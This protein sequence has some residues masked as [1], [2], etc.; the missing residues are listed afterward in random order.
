MTYIYDEF[1]DKLKT[2]QNFSLVRYGDGEW[3]VILKKEPLYSSVILRRF[4]KVDG[5]IRSGDVMLNIIKSSPKYYFGLQ[6]LALNL[7]PEDI[8]NT[9]PADVNVVNSD[10]LHRLSEMGSLGD[11]FE[12]L[13]TR[14]L[15]LLGPEY[16]KNLKFL[17]FDHVISPDPNS[18]DYCDELQLQI[19]EKLIG[20]TN[21]VILYSASIA[22]KIIIDRIY[23]KYGETLTQIDTGSLLDPYAGVCTREYHKT[24][25]ERLSFKSN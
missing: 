25:L 7:W 16:L 1:M 23:N 13:K 14:E 6:N 9:I 4:E 2:Q 24:V 5:L 22:A 20:K 3:A 8:E 11:F 15:I 19:E 12:V 17:K 18:W 21:P 10:M